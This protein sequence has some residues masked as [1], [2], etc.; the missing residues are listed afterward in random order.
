MSARIGLL[1]FLVGCTSSNDAAQLG[2]KDLAGAG[3][4]QDLAGLPND[5]GGDMTSPAGDAAGPTV[6][7]L[8]PACDAPPPDPGAATGFAG[9][10]PLGSANH[11]GR[12]LFVKEGDAQWI[13]A[14]FAYGATA[15]ESGISG[16]AVDIYVL[17]SCGTT[18]Q[19]LGTAT[20]SD[21]STGN[22]VEGVADAKGRLFFGIEKGKHLPLGRHRVHLVLKADLSSTDLF[23]EVVKAGT[24][25][26]VTDVDGTL[27]SSENAQFTSLFTGTDPS[28]NADAATALTK[29]AER[30]YRPMYLT[31]RPEWLVQKSRDW[32]SSN[33]FPAGILHTTLG[34]TGALGSSAATF[35]SDELDAE[36]ARGLVL[37][38]A[39]G[40][41]STDADAYDHAGVMPLVDRIFYQ[42]TDDAYGGRRIEAYSEL[43]SEFATLPLVCQ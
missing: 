6:C 5:G 15:L 38:Y 32:L 2:G 21:G 35:K 10:P 26:F 8:P 25:I 33:G 22:T 18:W 27:T 17:P 12:D 42:Y 7:A 23:L 14:H 31:A 11:R 43:T 13:L 34:G 3:S 4:A 30:G 19:K 39:I 41:T 20:T 28:A 29:L 40:N 24:K 37:S 1:V 16:E 36:K 9:L